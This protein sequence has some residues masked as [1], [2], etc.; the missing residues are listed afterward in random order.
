MKY[1]ITGGTGTLGSALVKRLIKDHEVRVY[2]RDEYKQS[3]M[4]REIPEAQY[5]LGDVRD[6]DRLK[7]ACQGVDVI[8][9]PAALKRMDTTSH[10]TYE[11]ADVNIRGTYNVCLAGEGKKIIH[12]STD[13]VFQPS[14]IYG[15]SKMI[16]ESIALANGAIVWRFGNFIGSRGSVWEIFARQKAQ[17]KPLTITDPEATRFMMKIEDVCDYVLS[18][19]GPGLHYPTNLTS[20]TIGQIA[21]QVAP[22]SKWEIIGLRE[23]EKLHESIAKEY[24]SADKIIPEL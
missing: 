5:W 19:V 23:G 17:G 16:A 24:I 15:A 11:V 6:L 20:M 3:E 21:K 12:I 10:N 9:H 18:E 1:L 14:C 2:S 4:M 22:D 13:K 7:N 8:I